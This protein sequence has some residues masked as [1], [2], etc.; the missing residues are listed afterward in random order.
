MN[1]LLGWM[2][3]GKTD[4]KLRW[5]F[6]DAQSSNSNSDEYTFSSVNVGPAVEGKK[7]YIAALSLDSGGNTFSS[8]TVG[9]VA[10]TQLVTW[11]APSS[12]AAVIAFYG[13]EHSGG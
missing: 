13:I 6:E 5:K 10:A 9:G 3:S 4:P 11:T 2:G 1:F 7:L 12:G 8:L